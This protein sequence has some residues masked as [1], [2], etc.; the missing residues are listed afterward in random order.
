M[1]RASKVHSHRAIC[2]LNRQSS[3][4]TMFKRCESTVVTK[5]TKKRS[6]IFGKIL[7]ATLLL[8]S[9]Y[10]GA[11]YYAL[12]DSSFRET[13][14]TYIPGA[15]ETVQFAD[16]VVKNYNMDKYFDQATEWKKQAEDLTNKAKEYSAKIQEATNDVYENLTG[17]KKSNVISV[18][19][20]VEKESLSTPT[21]TVTTIKMTSDKEIKAPVV[22]VAIEKPEPIHVKSIQSDNAVVRELSQIVVELA[23]ILNQSGLSGLGREII[24]DAE[25]KI[26]KLNERFLAVDTEQATILKSLESLKE[27]GDKIQGSLDAFRAEALKTIESTHSE[28]ASNIVAREA[29]LKN[30]FEQTR[31]EMKTSFAQQLAAD[32]SAQQ[33]RLE[34]A[35]TDALIEQAKELQRRFVKEVKFLV[36]QERAGRLAKLDQVSQRFT[37]LE[38]YTL[39]N[40][41][42]LDKSRQYHVIHITLDAFQ[43]ALDAQQKQPFVDELQALDHNTKDDEVIQTVLSVISKEIAEEG[44][45]TVSEL[46]VR[47]EEV[48]Q[49]VRRVALVPEDGGFGSHIIS[50]L[51]S[52]LMFKKSGLSEG[53]DVESIL[54]RTEYYLKRDNL[55]HAT[56]ELN[57]LK[58]WPKK[59][60]QDWIQ[61]ARHHL[62]VKQA[63]EVAETQAVLLSL[64][65]V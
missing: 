21:D 41:Q 12:N 7:G 11:T 43:D 55:E 4:I 44:V 57:Q 65:E 20:A 37:A 13:F 51:M 15:K 35:R 32:L 40:A 60:A 38:K 62:E 63:L 27:K 14:T 19:E 28:A 31:A 16:N 42:A 6:G 50:I 54:A 26:E 48:S 25:T 30:Q 47:F 39:Q 49:E 18:Q 8:S 10:G 59:L 52:W 22:E 1:L 5:E 34:K 53:D 61:S 9:G 58:G 45:N 36:E 2:S 17:Q 23:S 24:K 33:E 3:G 56:R 46:A 64:L 29:Q